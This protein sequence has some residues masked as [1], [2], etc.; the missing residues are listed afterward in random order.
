MQVISESKVMPKKIEFRSVAL[1]REKALK[2]K[3]KSQRKV[4]L[5]SRA[6][7][8]QFKSK[9]ECSPESY[10]KGSDMVVQVAA[11]DASAKCTEKGTLVLSKLLVKNSMHVPKL[12]DTL[13]N[14]GQ[15]CDDENFY[16]HEEGVNH[17]KFV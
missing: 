6:S 14:V 7:I 9:S 8:S 13:I 4:Y 5:D 16:P 17:H 2:T 1:P 10:E 11:G 12:N 15:I 3:P